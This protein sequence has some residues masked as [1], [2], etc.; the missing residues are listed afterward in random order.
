[1]LDQVLL[2]VLGLL[3]LVA[4]AEGAGGEGHV[5]LPLG[6]PPQREA[7]ELHSGQRAGLALEDDLCLANEALRGAIPLHEYHAHR[8]LLGVDR[9]PVGEG[10]ARVSLAE[11][12]AAAGPFR[13]RWS[14]VLG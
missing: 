11:A 5:D 13:Y 6:R 3:A 14:R 4:G 9:L 8:N 7:D 12:A 10:P 1:M 2:F